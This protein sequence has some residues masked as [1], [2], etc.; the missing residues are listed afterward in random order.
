MIRK[1]TKS[2]NTQM[3]DALNTAIACDDMNTMHELLSNNID[4]NSTGSNGFYPAMV[5]IEYGNVNALIA[6]IKR[7]AN[8]NVVYKQ[9]GYSILMRALSLKYIPNRYMIVATLLKNGADVNIL[10]HDSKTALY[11]ART[12]RPAYINILKRYGGQY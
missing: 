9:T 2:Q 7:G 1:K 3:I 8:V 4:I 5:S 6:L 12:K 10:S 11:I